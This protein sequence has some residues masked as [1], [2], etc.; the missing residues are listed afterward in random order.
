MRKVKLS[1]K[2]QVRERMV[3]NQLSS[4]V[5]HG[6]IETTLPKARFLK[7]SAQRFFSRVNSLDALEKIKYCKTKLYGGASSKA[8]DMT[9]EKVALFKMAQRFGDNALMAKVRLIEKEL[10][11]KKPAEKI[12]KDDKSAKG[13]RK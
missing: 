10:P 1:L 6:E 2:H 8:I 12:S 7:S 3:R 13:A 11:E 9:V 5:L 4:L